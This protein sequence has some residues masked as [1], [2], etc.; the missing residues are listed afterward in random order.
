MVMGIGFLQH[1]EAF[2]LNK[3]WDYDVEDLR[4]YD[5]IFT[6]KDF[7]NIDWKNLFNIEPRDYQIE[8]V[9]TALIEKNGHISVRTGGGKTLIL[10]MIV[11][12]LNLPTLVLFDKTDL[13]HQTMKEFQKFGFDKKDLGIVQGSN[14][15]PARI[16]FATIQSKDK[17]YDFLEMFKVVVVDESHGVRAN[18]YQELLIQSQASR[19]YGLSA[20]PLSS[21]DP[22]EKAKT[23]QYIGRIIFKGEDTNALVKKGVLAKAKILFIKCDRGDNQN[24]VW[25]ASGRDYSNLY[26]QEIVENEYRNALIAK[27][28]SVKKNKKI[29][30]LYDIIEHGNVLFKELQKLLPNRKIHL[31][32]GKDDTKVRSKTL[33]V[34]EKSNNDIIVASSIFNTGINVLSVNVVINAAGTKSSIRSLQKLGRGLRRTADKDEMDYIDFYDENS[35]VMLAQSKKRIK[36]YKEEGHLVEIIEAD[37]I[38]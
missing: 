12:L 38:R 26:K 5:R 27:L 13:V 3:G 17:I 6:E 9:K 20:T 8:A 10:A 18:S 16:T 31:L 2:I 1:L 37:M 36:T 33:E 11:K 32:S 23:I 4:E 19:R 28:C 24:V 21:D 15:R 35:R 14:N 25:E 34:F 29:I 7:E 22:S 30:V